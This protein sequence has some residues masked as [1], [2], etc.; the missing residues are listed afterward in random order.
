MAIATKPPVERRDAPAISTVYLNDDGLHHAR[1]GEVLAFLRRRQGLELDFHCRVCHEHIALT[2]YALNRI[3]V[4][5]APAPREGEA[6][7]V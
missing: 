7:L 3:P 5:T 1:C 2:E 6:V 4:G